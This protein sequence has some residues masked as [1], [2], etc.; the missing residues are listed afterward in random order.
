LSIIFTKKAIFRVCYWTMTPIYLHS[1]LVTWAKGQVQTGAAASVEGLV[2]EAVIARKRD[3]EWLDRTIKT[4]LHS[5]SVEGWVN[6]ES[7][8]KSLDQWI[9][10]LDL[11]IEDYETYLRERQLNEQA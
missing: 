2:G 7:F 8:M 1:D 5:V 9:S 6:G 3:T 4:T 10:E 11:R